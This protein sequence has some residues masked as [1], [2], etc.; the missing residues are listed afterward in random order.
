MTLNGSARFERVQSRK[1]RESSNDLPAPMKLYRATFSPP[2]TD[3]SR[4][5]YF[6]SFAMRRYAMHG[7]IRSAGSST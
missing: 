2:M 6:E 7:V 1:D 4:K 5:L 3:S